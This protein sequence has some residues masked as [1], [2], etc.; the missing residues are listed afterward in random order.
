MTTNCPCGSDLEYALCCGRVH[1]SGAGL[2]M[3]A[4]SLM[5]ARYAA[6]VLRDADFLL[7]S[8]HPTTRP[9]EVTFDADLEWL[10]LEV[11]A[12]NAGTGFDNEGTVEFR[13]RFRRGSEHLEL[14][15]LSSFT[16]LDG[17]WVYVEGI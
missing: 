15:E 16:R 3:S 13:A 14:H 11:I 12:T 7:T 17:R 10:G 5:R 2:G 6:Y 8:W 4:A 1:R 9:S